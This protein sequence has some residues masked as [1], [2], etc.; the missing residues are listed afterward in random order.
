MSLLWAVVGLLSG[1]LLFIATPIIVGPRLG[2]SNRQRILDFYAE[3]A[4]VAFGRAQLLRR[5]HGGHTIRASE[6]DSKHEAEKFSLGG[7]TKH[8]EDVANLMSRLHNKA[9]GM[10]YEDSNVIIDPLHAE[11]GEFHSE[12]VAAGKHQAAERVTDENGETR[13]REVYTPDLPVPKVTRLVDLAHISSLVPGS[14][15]LGDT[16]QAEEYVK[17]SLEGFKSASTMEYM[18]V[19]MGFGVGFGV[20]FLAMSQGGSIT[21][22]VS[23]SLMPAPT[24]VLG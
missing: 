15:K 12:Q 2:A 8:A 1:V 17:I 19:L 13:E 20:V 18:I 24:G 21:S 3:M 4:M 16:E 9:F 11:A 23:L 5:L 14:A 22:T 10:V 7:E 6:Y